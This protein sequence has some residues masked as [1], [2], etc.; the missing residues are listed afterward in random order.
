MV[1]ENQD[2]YCPPA[3]ETDL[4]ILINKPWWDNTHSGPQTSSGITE[5]WYPEF[6]DGYET[7]LQQEAPTS[8]KYQQGS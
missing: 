1:K 3:R 4:I 8:Q 2:H 5:E 6:Q 7:P